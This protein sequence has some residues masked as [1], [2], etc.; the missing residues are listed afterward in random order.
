MVYAPDEISAEKRA[1]IAAEEKAVRM[2]LGPASELV[3]MGE[4]ATTDYL[5]NELSITDRLDASIDRYLK[6]LLMVRGV[7][8]MTVK[9][10]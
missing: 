4:V 3:D 8:S 6:R 1:E 2:E 10:S 7:K 9:P 5:L